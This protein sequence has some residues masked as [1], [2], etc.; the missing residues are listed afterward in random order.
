MIF[1]FKYVLVYPMGLHDVKKNRSNPGWSMNNWN[2]RSF[3]FSHRVNQLDA[4][5]IADLSKT[6]QIF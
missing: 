2:S 6:F 3:Y 4:L 1:F 5:I